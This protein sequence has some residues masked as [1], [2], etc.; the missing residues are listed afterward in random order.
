MSTVVTAK[1]Q[2]QFDAGLETRAD[3]TIDQPLERYSRVDHAVWAQLYARQ[4]ALLEG[5][6]ADAFVAGMKRLT[7]PADRVP[8]FEEVNRQLEPATGWKIVAVP[9]LVPGDVFFAHLAERRF[10]VTWWMRR[11]DQLDYLQEPDCFHDLFGHVPLLIDPVFADY[12]HAYGRAALAVA[13]D[14]F[15]LSLLG[16]LYWYTVEF[17]LIRSRHDR[18]TLQ[19]YGAG[20]V[21]SRGESVYS[22]ES[23]APNRIGF[24]LDRVMRTAYRIDTFQKTYFVIDDFEQ[25]FALLKVDAR[26]LAR[27]LA[28]MSEYPAGAVLDGDRVIHR[29]TGEGWAQDQ[30]ATH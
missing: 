2:E 22:L 5:R 3:F 16:R 14:P 23:E 27:R 10:P 24:E 30:D 19:I 12:M 9:G 26:A 8:S 7:L 21:S 29:G 13:D 28:G 15:A 25:L 4:T 11:P 1:L 17:G 6:A 18:D 20:I